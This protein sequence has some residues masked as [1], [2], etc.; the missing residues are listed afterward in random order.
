[1]L[2]TD[3]LQVKTNIGHSEAASGLSALIKA[4]LI[5]EKGIIPPTVGPS[6]LNPKSK[7]NL[8]CWCL[9]NDLT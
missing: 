1:M 4:C 3:S 2:P 8:I 9:E 5:V 7:L 6:R